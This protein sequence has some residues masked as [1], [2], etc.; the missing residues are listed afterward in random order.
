[1]LTQG[2]ADMQMAGDTD[3]MIGTGKR[4]Y[5]HRD[6]DWNRNFHAPGAGGGQLDAPSL[7]RSDPWI[8]PLGA[9][10][11]AARER[12][13]GVACRG[14]RRP[15]AHERL[16]LRGRVDRRHPRHASREERGRAMREQQHEPHQPHRE[17]RAVPRANAPT[18]GL[19][20]TITMPT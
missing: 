9:A 14:Q 18:L 12:T 15:A 11:N 5:R 2:N 13:A 1:M 10:G 4:E 6:V 3:M 8:D 20:I 17:R 16:L 19:Q 7:R